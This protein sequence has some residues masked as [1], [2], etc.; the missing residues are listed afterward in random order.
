VRPR[1]A[2]RR[3]TALVAAIVGVVLAG[4]VGSCSSDG[5]SA[6]DTVDATAAVTALVNWAA[7]EMPSEVDENGDVEAPVVYVT[8][9]SGGRLDAGL[10]ASVVETTTE[11]ATVRFA[12]DRSE[13]VDDTSELMIVHDDGVMLVLGDLPEPA[14]TLTVDVE[15]YRSIDEASNLVVTV[16]ADAEGAIVTNSAAG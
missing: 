15:W 14:R 9:E 7:A 10:Q 13:A 16:T 6:Q 2:T 8:T 4:V 12:D 3:R 1:R 5:E 11:V